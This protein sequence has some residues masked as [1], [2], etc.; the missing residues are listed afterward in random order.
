L[1]LT[2]DPATVRQKD[3]KDFSRAVA[4]VVLNEPSP[5]YFLCVIRS[6]DEEKIRFPAIIFRKGDRKGK[7]EG[8]VRWKLIL[9]ETRVRLSAYNADAPDRRLTFTVA[10]VPA[11]EM[12]PR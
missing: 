1:T 10:L 8:T 2:I 11:Q 6:E 5:A 4:T 7:T 3:G 12:P 9:R